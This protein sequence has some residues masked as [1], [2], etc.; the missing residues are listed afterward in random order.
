LYSLYEK[1]LE[2][3]KVF[4]EEEYKSW[5]SKKKEEEEKKYMDKL[6]EKSVKKHDLSHLSH[7]PTSICGITKDIHPYRETFLVVDFLL[8]CVFNRVKEIP[9]YFELTNY[10]KEIGNEK[11]LNEL[12]ESLR[13]YIHKKVEKTWKI[14]EIKKALRKEE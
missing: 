11:G 7:S 9:E 13:N 8:F 6:Y 1:I 3:I 4:V 14:D 12:I 2:N 10:L 5:S